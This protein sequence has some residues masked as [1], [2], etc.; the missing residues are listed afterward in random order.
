MRAQH[1]VSLVQGMD[2][3]QSVAAAPP[4]DPASARSATI[5]SPVAAV[6]PD[7]DLDRVGD[8]LLAHEALA[9][10]HL[11]GSYGE[12]PSTGLQADI[13]GARALLWEPRAGAYQPRALVAAA[14][15]AQYP[16]VGSAFAVPQTSRVQLF[17]P[18]AGATGA[19]SWA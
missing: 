19:Y 13:L 7:I 9:P 11:D 5:A 12:A 15:A 16:P 17:A 18:P 1:V 6:Q 8:S 14:A 10:A 2:A 4:P 3:V